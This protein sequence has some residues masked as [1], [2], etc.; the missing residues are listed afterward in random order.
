MAGQRALVMGASGFVGS[1]VTRL[2]VERGEEVSVLVRESSNTRAFDDLPVTRHSGGIEDPES[3]RRAMVDCDVV[4][5]CI[6][7]TRAWL[8]DP[9][10]LFETNVEGLRRV[11]DVAVNANLQ[12]FVFCS[13]IGA[14]AI[15]GPD[16]KVNEDKAFNWAG[17]GGPYIESRR[18]AEDLVLEYARNRG[19]PAVALNISNTY[20]PGDWAPTPHGGL[21]AAA[22]LGKLP[23]YLNNV[24]SE[25]VGIEDAAEA[26]ILASTKG[27]IGERY[28][29]SESFMSAKEIYSLAAAEAGVPAPKYGI[30]PIALTVTGFLA[31]T[32][33]KLLRRDYPFNM[34][35]VRLMRHV[36]PL[37]H[38]KATR[39][40]GWVPRPTADSIRAAARFALDRR[41]QSSERK[42]LEH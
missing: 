21:V 13:T 42:A 5:Y 28:I 24:H 12:R 3:I 37:D 27:R 38:S 30:P 15:G 19:L 18:Q 36:S 4:Y 16:E 32:I 7:D 2:L 22:A 6:V 14:I 11:L 31:T 8:S 41:R 20:G 17:K 29:V 9:S 34:V 35:G 25:V 33:G 26:M 23:F 40:L 10:P 1:T 39:E